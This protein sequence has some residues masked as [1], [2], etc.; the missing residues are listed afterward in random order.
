MVE[1]QEETL[2]D[3]Y[4]LRLNETEIELTVAIGITEVALDKDLKFADYT[5][6]HRRCS[7]RKG[8]L[9]NSAKFTGKHLWQSFFFNKVEGLRPGWLLLWLYRA[10][11]AHE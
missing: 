9:W 10:I 7:V 1:L 11:G 5:S 2:P 8:V 3:Y 4:P 6:S